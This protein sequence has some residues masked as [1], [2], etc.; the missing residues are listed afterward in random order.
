MPSRKRPEDRSVLAHVV[1][2]LFL[3][4][5]HERLNSE[6][7][8]SGDDVEDRATDEKQQP[9]EGDDRLCE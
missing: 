7:D 5:E 9:A 1:S 6:S 2:N 3:L 4:S 8:L